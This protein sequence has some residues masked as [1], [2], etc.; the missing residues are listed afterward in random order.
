MS[1]RPSPSNRWQGSAAVERAK[2][3]DAES[4]ATDL[5]AQAVCC[6]RGKFIRLDDR[7]PDNACI[8]ANMTPAGNISTSHTGLQ[9][10]VS[11]LP[12]VL[13]SSWR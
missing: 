4:H 10:I 9:R 12:R 3:R 5:H 2:G 1:S 6:E 11:L 7:T 13:P 8:H